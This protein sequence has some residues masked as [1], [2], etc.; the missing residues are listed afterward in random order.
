MRESPKQ[1]VSCCN[2]GKGHRAWQ[3][4]QGKTF[5]AYWEDIQA[6][7]VR[8]V[9]ETAVIRRTESSQNVPY[10]F[11][12][13]KRG[14]EEAPAGPLPKRGPGRP[15]LG[16]LARE[17]AQGRITNLFATA[18]AAQATSGF[19][20]LGAGDDTGHCTRLKPAR[21]PSQWIHQWRNRP[22]PSQQMSGERA[23]SITERLWQG[24][25]GPGDYLKQLT[26]FQ[27]NCGAANYGVSRPI[28][29]AVAPD[30]HNILAIQEPAYN[31]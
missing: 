6:K 5:Q 16:V 29:D 12:G 4:A 8:L 11:V 26:I 20:K 17:G 2:C 18:S 23:Q 1:R 21:H 10:Q 15:P 19:M 7:R 14:R 30:A 3:K 27:F 24:S 9:A 25:G 13:G 22:S 28:F 31:N